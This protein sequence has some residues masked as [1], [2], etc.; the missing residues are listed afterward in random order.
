MSA[1]I[2]DMART[3]LSFN[4]CTCHVLDNCVC[5]GDCECVSRVFHRHLIENNSSVSATRAVNERET[6]M[7]VAT[8]SPSALHIYVS[9]SSTLC[10]SLSCMW[11]FFQFFSYFFFVFFVCR[12]H[13]NDI[14]DSEKAFFC[15]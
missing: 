3:M 1:A 7:S 4:L 5:L 13:V 6:R 8:F 12:Q 11:H 9:L 2:E 15:T 10:P 14:N